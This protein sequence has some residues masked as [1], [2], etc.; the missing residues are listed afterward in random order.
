[1]KKKIIISI[2]IILLIIFFYSFSWAMDIAAGTKLW[3]VT[4][5][6]WFKKPMQNNP[7]KDKD[8][9]FKLE[10][11]IMAGPSL[12]FVFKD[13]SIST[14]FNYGRFEGGMNISG[15]ENNQDINYRILASVI[16][17]DFDLSASYNIITRLKV[18]A[19]L[20][21]QVYN[22]KTST[23]YTSSTNNIVTAVA[24][25]GMKIKSV[26]NGPGIGAAYIYN[27]SKYFIGASLAYIFL[28]GK[29]QME[30][31][32]QNR[33]NI[34]TG[35]TTPSDWVI[36][37][38]SVGIT[39]EPMLGFYAGEHAVL[40]L[41]IRAQTLTS[42]MTAKEEK[43]KY[44]IYEDPDTGKPV[45]SSKEKDQFGGISLSLSILF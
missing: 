31:N 14:G 44:S 34:Q 7:L 25:G 37:V 20:K 2:S 17:S 36:N 21:T 45:Y 4:W 3:I 16:R 41:G 11:T 30:E 28:K 39:F 15:E 5:D 27:W 19:G 26:L 18:F 6:P 40:I 42:E 23:I 32:D 12:T 8:A 22:I 13:W 33:V 35:S 24:G 43:E 9:E 1:M 29:Y 10:T 38:K